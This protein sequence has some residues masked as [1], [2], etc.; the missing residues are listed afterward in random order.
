MA[1]TP[2]GPPYPGPAPAVP[3]TVGDPPVP[4]KPP[5]LNMQVIGQAMR[6]DAARGPTPTRCVKLNN[7]LVNEI[8]E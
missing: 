2:S 7:I 8:I 3:T 5:R 6:A 1:A 4:V